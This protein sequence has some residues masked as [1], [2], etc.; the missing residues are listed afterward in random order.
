MK[1]ISTRLLVKGYADCFYFYRDVMG[2]EVMWGDE[3]T[4]YASFQASDSTRLALFGR[5]DM[6]EAIGTDDL[7]PDA[8]CQD[9]AMLIFEV[10]DLEGTVKR[11]K[12]KGAAFLTGIVDYPD[13]GIRAA[14]MRDPDGTLIELNTPIPQEEWSDELRKKDDATGRE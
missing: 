7:Q 12:E 14:H 9:R 3:N 6:A 2:I 13:W 11:L 5:R 8:A 10:D 4:G 1:L